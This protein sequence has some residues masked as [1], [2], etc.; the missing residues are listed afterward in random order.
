MTTGQTLPREEPVPA[1]ARPRRWA[2]PAAQVGGLLLAGV[3]IWLAARGMDLGESLRAADDADLFGSV[4]VLGTALAFMALKTVRWRLI[5]MPIARV[6]FNTL[7]RLVYIGTAANIIVP[8]SGELVRSTSLARLHAGPLYSGSVLGTVAIERLLDFSILALLSFVAILLEPRV[9]HWISMAGLLAF[10]TVIAGV[11]VITA[12][13][14]PGKRLRRFGRWLLSPLS[15]RFGHWLRHHAVRALDGLATLQS[16]GRV[17][18]VLALSLAQWS[19]VVLAIWISCRALG[20]TVSPS[21]AISVFVL[22]VIGLTLPSAPGQVGT[23]Q[24][25]FVAG[26]KLAGEDTGL[27]LAASL[28]YNVW[29][30]LATAV[31]GGLLWLRRPRRPGPAGS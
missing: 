27:A 30:V 6:R 13:R 22:T 19:M 20:V 24:L 9:S 4:L 18:A 1:P 7:H 14:D 12:L 26:L 28:V 17:L 8:H 31:I 10:A 5:L 23:T 3:F 16:P 11:S 25:A 21:T 29:F 15:G 2:R